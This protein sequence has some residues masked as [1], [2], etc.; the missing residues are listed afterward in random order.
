MPLLT[1]RTLLTARISGMI[2]AL[3]G[4]SLLLVCT[5]VLQ[6]QELS[7]SAEQVEAGTAVYKET[8]QLCHG[9]SL[10]NGQFGTPL[11]GNY[12]RKKWGGKSLGELLQFTLESMPPDNK[13]GLPAENYAAALAYILSRNDIAAGAAAMPVDPA[14]LQN[15]PLP[16][17]AP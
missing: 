11:R 13:G 3:A 15:V 10:S 17:P 7:F 16:W 9:T 2:R 5:S 1:A 8:C 12:F 4:T 6:A 14:A